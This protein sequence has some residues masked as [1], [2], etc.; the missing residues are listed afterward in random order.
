MNTNPKPL[1][2]GIG[3]GTGAGKTTIARAIMAELPLNAVAFLQHDWY[4]R[5]HPDMDPSQRTQLNFDH[6]DSLENELLATHLDMLVNNKTVD[7]PNYDFVT[8][9]RLTETTPLEPAPVILVEGILIFADP[10]LNERYDIRLYIDTPA[11]IRVLRR[12]RRDIEQRGRSFE[13]IR[14][15]YYDTVRPMHEAFV[16]PAKFRADII[17]PEGG[18]QRV[19]IDLV[20]ERI[21]RELRNRG[22]DK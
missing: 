20:V 1:V 9:R 17:I 13:E 6:P 3:G 12:V 14:R 5:D 8:H 19:A 4:Y 22:L 21:R 11:D 16:Y 15:Q 18:N 10:F 2:I 7:R